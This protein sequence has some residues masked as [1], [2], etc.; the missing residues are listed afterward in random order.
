MI[1]TSKQVNDWQE[2]N[3]N[4]GI[5]E[6]LYTVQQ[7]NQIHM[8]STPLPPFH[9]AIK[10]D[11]LER[12]DDFYGS[13]LQCQKG[14]SG[15]HWT[16]YNFF[17]H[18]LVCHLDHSDNK[19]EISNHV[20]GEQVPVPHFGVVISMD[21]WQALVDKLSEAD[22][23]FVIDPSVRFLGQAGEQAT[24]FVRD[25]AGNVLEFKSFAN[26]TMLFQS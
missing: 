10:V 6:R 15:S 23:D 8:K 26:M 25:P 14:R 13:L 9:L 4:A 5:T 22:V 18:Q 24:C 17:G 7:W 20:D 1:V 21:E 16:D 12:A 11:S 2:K 19:R 3:P